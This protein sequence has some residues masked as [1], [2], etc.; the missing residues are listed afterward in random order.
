VC[1]G[2]VSLSA[3]AGS[4]GLASGSIDFGATINGRLPFGSLVLG[5]VALAVVVGLPMAVACVADWRGAGRA[6]QLS[7]GAGG[8]LVGWIVVEVVVTRSFSWLQPTMAMIGAAIGFAGYRQWNLT[9]GAT[10]D[11]VAG[12]MPG[13]EIGVPAAF[14]ATRAISIAAPP[15]AVW[16][17]LAQVGVGRAGFYSYDGLDNGGVPSAREILTGFQQ[18]AVGDL[19]APMTYP[20]SPN[21]SFTVASFEFERALVWAKADGVWAWSLV[22]DG[23]GTRL[24]VRLLT[25]PDWRHAARS[26]IG[27]VL[28]EVGDFPMMRKMLLGIK[29]RAECLATARS[30]LL[31]DARQTV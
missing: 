12:P 18:V 19:A 2:A 22:P 26:L 30:T 6:N 14:S 29:E 11:E 24:V 21:T 1:E 28:V 16:P 4:A 13:D 23:D 7:M 15:E 9:W 31:V 10:H 17:W 25:G 5:A 8:L 27:G 20:P 3:L